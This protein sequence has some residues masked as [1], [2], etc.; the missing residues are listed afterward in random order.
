MPITHWPD[1]HWRREPTLCC[2]GPCIFSLTKRITWRNPCSSLYKQ[3]RRPS[4]LQTNFYL[5]DHFLC[6]CVGGGR[7]VVAG[8]RLCL[9]HTWAMFLSHNTTSLCVPLKPLPHRKGLSQTTVLM[10]SFHKRWASCL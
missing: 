2:E 8:L 1:H 4:C 7:V 10:F 3:L 9:T 6:V 5:H